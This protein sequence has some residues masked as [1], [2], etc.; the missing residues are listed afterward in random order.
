[1]EPRVVRVIVFTDE[2]VGCAHRC[3]MT[4]TETGPWLLDCEPDELER[5]C[6]PDEG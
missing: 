4:R 2:E 3:T 5:D 6:D 1:M